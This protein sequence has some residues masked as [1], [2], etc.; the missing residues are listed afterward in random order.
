MSGRLLAKAAL[1]LAVV[2]GLTTAA[3]N[4]ARIADKSS[5]PVSTEGSGNSS[6]ETRSLETETAAPK[7][8][9]KPRNP[10]VLFITSKGCERCQKEL[11]R[12]QQRGGEFETMQ[13]RGWKVGTEADNHIQIVDAEQ[14]PDLIRKLN[15]REFPT[16]ACVNDGEIIRSFKDGCSTPLDVWTF[17]WLM[18]GESERPQGVIPE[19]IRVQW[20]GQYPLRGNH[21]TVEGDWNPSKEKVISHLRGENH[22][23]QLETYGNIETWSHEEIRSLHDDLHEKYGGG[24]ASGSF[25]QSQPVNRGVNEFRGGRKF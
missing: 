1:L 19:A 25:A 22:L 6:P 4:D 8:D 10:R 24:V 5:S 18:K 23:N 9:V 13:A 11:D 15:V 3:E 21:W 12:L 2:T 7:S 17:G 14:I 20:T 16:V